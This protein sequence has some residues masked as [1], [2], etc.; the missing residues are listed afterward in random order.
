MKRMNSITDMEHNRYYLAY[1]NGKNESETWD[2][3]ISF[4]KYIGKFKKCIYGIKVQRG[5]FFDEKTQTLGLT[6][7]VEGFDGKEDIL[8]HMYNI[9][10]GIFL[11]SE[12]E[13]LSHIVM[14]EI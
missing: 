3:S 5:F 13:V 8:F 6:R 12:E 4:F 11:L 2:K 14:E 9:Y 7:W 1:Y 10:G